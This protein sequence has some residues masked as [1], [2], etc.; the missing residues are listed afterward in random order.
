MRQQLVVIRDGVEDGGSVLTCGSCVTVD[1]GWLPADRS[2]DGCVSQPR[3][4]PH[5]EQ[6]THLFTL[7][8]NKPVK[9][10]TEYSVCTGWWW[11]WAGTVD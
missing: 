6:G 9:E 5:S 2:W 10:R 11:C 3:Q 8:H 4:A 1:A 7:T